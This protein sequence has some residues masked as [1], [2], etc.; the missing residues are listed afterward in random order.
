MDTKRAGRTR[1]C[2]GLLRVAGG[3]RCLWKHRGAAFWLLW[4]LSW[5]L[6][7]GIRPYSRDIYHENS[8]RATFFFRIW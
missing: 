6:W 3:G 8:G 2:A 7:L 5:K 4:G 1:C